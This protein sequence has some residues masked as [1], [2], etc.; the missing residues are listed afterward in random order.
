[1]NKIFAIIFIS[2]FAF[3]CTKKSEKENM[4]ESADVS[5]L[6]RNDDT[7]IATGNFK[8][9]GERKSYGTVK[10]YT[11]SNYKTLR[12]ENF[13]C[14]NGPDLKLHLA[15]DSSGLTSTYY[16]GPLVAVSGNF[17]YTFSVN[18]NMAVQRYVFVQ[19]SVTKEHFALCVLN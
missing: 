2:L 16:L 6:P 17:N 7:L 14:D 15:S 10:V 9:I 11:N 13:K 19:S 4:P 3:A 5:F 1:M 8:Q 18:T 12:F